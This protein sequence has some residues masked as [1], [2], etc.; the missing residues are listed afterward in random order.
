[1]T[2]NTEANSEMYLKCTTQK[3]NKLKKRKHVKYN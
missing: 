2:L 1:M 3:K